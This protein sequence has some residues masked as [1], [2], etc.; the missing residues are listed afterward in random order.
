MKT[1]IA[2]TLYYSNITIKAFSIR[3]GIV[4]GIMLNPYQDAQLFAPELIEK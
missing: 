3:A 1:F 4:V 2:M